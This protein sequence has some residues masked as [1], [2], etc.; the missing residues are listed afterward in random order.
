[1]ICKSWFQSEVGQSV[2]RQEQLELVT[3]LPDCRLSNALQIGMPAASSLLVNVQSMVRLVLATDVESDLAGADLIADPVNLPLDNQSVELVVLHHALETSPNPHAVLRE[4]SRVVSAGG[5]LVIIAF[6]PWSFAGLW[7]ISQR[8]K[9]KQNQLWHSPF[10]PAG[11][12]QDWM[13][14]LGFELQSGRWMLYRPPFVNA[15]SWQKLRFL[16]II[17]DRWWPA[18]G[19]V[20]LLVAKKQQP[21]MWYLN[22]AV[23]FRRRY[24]PAFAGPAMKR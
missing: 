11:H 21:G 14:V 22:D 6:N 9:S 23:P 15:W 4:A 1:M 13:A 18:L 10:I 12:I 20:S 16:E 17:G 19:G 5:L 7:R 3:A 8:C 2:L 24:R